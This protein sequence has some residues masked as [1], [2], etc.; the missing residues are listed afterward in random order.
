MSCSYCDIPTR[1]QQELTTEEILV[2][3]DELAAAGVQ[4]LGL[5]GGEPLTHPGLPQI[6][7]RTRERGLYTTLDTSGLYVSKR[8]DW[9]RD[10]DHLIVSIDGPPAQHDANRGKGS[11]KVAEGALRFAASQSPKKPVWT[12]TVLTR[13]NLSGIDYVLD[14]CGEVGALATFQVLHHGDAMAKG[15]EHL[16]PEDSDTREAVRHLLRRKRQGAP[17]ASSYRYLEYLL[18]WDDYARPQKDHEFGDLRCVAGSLYA[19]VD[20]DGT[21]YPCSLLVEKVPGRNVKQGG[22]QAA[23]DAIETPACKACIASCYT[24]YNRLFSLDAATVAEWVGAFY[25]PPSPGWVSPR[26]EG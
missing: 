26:R 13:H 8:W 16:L 5:W 25:T 11:Q 22:F 4:R 3:V 7:A 6:L 1:Q 18:A 2:L 12:I 9:L 24:E 14:L 15:H 20:A 19:N 10:L 17:V 21:V 23:F